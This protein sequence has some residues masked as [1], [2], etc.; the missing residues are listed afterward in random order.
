M[1]YRDPKELNPLENIKESF[2]LKNK[3]NPMICAIKLLMLL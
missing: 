2:L 3:G 1:T